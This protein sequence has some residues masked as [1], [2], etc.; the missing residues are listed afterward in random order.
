M[1]IHELVLA[2]LAMAF[3]LGTLVWGLFSLGAE[4]ARAFRRILKGGGR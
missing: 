1:K 3:P 4:H 2:A